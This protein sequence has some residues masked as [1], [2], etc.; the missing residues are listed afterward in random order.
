MTFDRILNFVLSH[1]NG[2]YYRI[3]FK[4][5]R[6]KV[7]IGR[8][9]RVRERL[10][11]K[12]PGRVIIGNGILID[13]RGHPVTPFTHSKNAL[14]RIGDNSF[15]NG[16]RFGCQDE[17]D[18]GPHAILGD[19][20]ILDTDFHSIEINRWSKDAVVL[21]APIKIG[22]NVWIAAGAVILKGVEIGENSVIGFASVVT[23]D[24]PPNSVAAG[25]PARVIKKL[26]I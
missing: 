26:T 14:I 6:K 7:T 22:R 10:K 16:T 2:I 23:D 20:R 15:V 4:L 12:G 5:L 11:I 13:G 8:N 24:V 17:I 1:T 18:I 21:H 9:F 25:N 19:A 3:K